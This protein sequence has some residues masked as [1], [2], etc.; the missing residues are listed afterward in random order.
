MGYAFRQKRHHGILVDALRDGTSLPELLGLR[1]LARRSVTTVRELLPRLRRR[2]LMEYLGPG[3]LEPVAEL[4]LSLD[5]LEDVL[6]AAAGALG[7]ASLVGGDRR[8][9][10]GR[11]TLLQV[12]SSKDLESGVRHALALTASTTTRLRRMVVPTSLARAVRLQLGLRRWLREHG[13]R[14]EDSLG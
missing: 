2:D 4:D 7:L 12:P 13:R 11:A 8:T 5:P 14:D 10:L 1:V 6:D 3:A 9:R